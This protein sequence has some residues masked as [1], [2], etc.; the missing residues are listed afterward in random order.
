MV[1]PPCNKNSSIILIMLSLLDRRMTNMLTEKDPEVT[2]MVGLRSG[3]KPT[4]RPQPGRTGRNAR[5]AKHLVLRP[6]GPAE[7]VLLLLDGNGLNS[8][9]VKTGRS[10][11]GGSLDGMFDL[12]S[13][14]RLVQIGLPG[15]NQDE[16]PCL[17]MFELS[18][19]VVESSSDGSAGF[20]HA[21]CH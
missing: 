20:C 5:G 16:S 21:F 8:R 19:I 13:H 1:L 7:I 3:M 6:L 18:Y 14:F 12:F 9:T 10:L 17:L 11:R 2:D 15:G 4:A